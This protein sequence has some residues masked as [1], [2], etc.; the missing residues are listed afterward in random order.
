MKWSEEERAVG[1]SCEDCGKS[2]SLGCGGESGGR[3]GGEGFELLPLLRGEGFFEGSV[4]GFELGREG[5][6]GLLADLI[7]E[8]E[9]LFFGG[10]ALGWGGEEIGLEGGAE[11]IDLGVVQGDAVEERGGERFELGDLRG[12]QADAGDGGGVEVRFGGEDPGGVGGEVLH[13]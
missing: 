7:E 10:V 9:E 8:S 4:L 13:S 3:L 2:G 1:W 5:G 12:S 6:E 11:G